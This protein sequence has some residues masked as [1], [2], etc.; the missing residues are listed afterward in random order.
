VPVTPELG[1]A[2]REALA[3]AGV[4]LEASDVVGR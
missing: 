2:A 4:A 1:A 3:A